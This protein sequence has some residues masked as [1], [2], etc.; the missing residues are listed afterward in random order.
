[1]KQLTNVPAKTCL[2]TTITNRQCTYQEL[3]FVMLHALS[4]INFYNSVC[5]M[6]IASPANS[7]SSNYTKVTLVSQW[8]AYLFCCFS[9]FDTDLVMNCTTRPSKIFIPQYLWPFKD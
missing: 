9:N 8:C 3:T 7:S 4:R 1:M 5:I 6:C 2:R